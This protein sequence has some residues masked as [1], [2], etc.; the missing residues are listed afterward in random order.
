M[1]KMA[2]LAYDIEHYY[3]E[4]LGPQRIAQILECPVELVYEWI[5]SNNLGLS[6][7]TYDP[8]DTINS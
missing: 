2:E 4:G 8:Y 7:E 3:I 1:S 5:E 6:E